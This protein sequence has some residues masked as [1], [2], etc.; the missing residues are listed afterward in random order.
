MNDPRGSYWRKW[1]LH[2]HTPASFHWNGGK[3]FIKMNAA[4]K[5]TALN[6]IIDTLNKSDVA[7]FA[8][9]DYWTFDGFEE[10][11]GH[12]GSGKANL[13]KTLFPGME[14]RVEAPVNYRLNVQVLLS[15]QLTRQQRADFK[16]A[17]RLGGSG[18]SISEEALIEFGRSLSSDKARKHGF[19]GNYAD[20]DARL[21]SLGSQTAEVTRESLVKAKKAIPEGNCL[22]VLPYDTSD[23]LAKLDW[24]EHP[25]AD[26]YFMQSADMFETRTQENVDLF[27]GRRTKANQAFFDHFLTTMGGKPKPAI[28]GSD[29]HKLSDYGSFPGDRATWIKADPT[30]E[31][32][33]KTL[34]EPLGRSYIGECPKQIQAIEQRPTK[35]IDYVSIKKK[36]ES[37]LSEHWFDCD[38]PINPGLVAIIGNK[39]TGKSALG[40]T[41]GLLGRTAKSEA[42]SFL[43][44]KR[45]RQPKNNKARHFEGKLIWCSGGEET[46]E[47][48]LNP[49]SN[50]YELIKYIPQNYLEALCNELGSVEETGFD[51]ELRSVI[52][53]HVSP[54]NRLGQASLED[55]IRYKTKEANDRIAILKS[56]L[57]GITESIIAL[58]KRASP[59]NKTKL[60]SA[61]ATKQNELKSHNENKPAAVPKPEAS[62]EQKKQAEA[63]GKQLSDKKTELERADEGIAQVRE[64]LSKV[65]LLLSSADRLVGRLENFQRQ[66]E[67]L[68]EEAIPLILDLGLVQKDV[69]SIKISTEPVSAKRSELI[70]EQAKL[71]AELKPEESNSKAAI[72]SNLAA[73]LKVI[74]S[75]LDAPSK[76]YEAYVER[77]AEWEEARNKLIGSTETPE[78]IEYYKAEVKK[79]SLIPKELAAERKKAESKTKEIFRE[80]ARLAETY[81]ELYAPVQEF[82]DSSSVARDQLQL[83]FDVQISDVGFEAAFF[84][85]VSQGVR[86]TY[87]GAEEGKKRLRKLLSDSDFASEDGV[88]K[89]VQKLVESL[90]VDKR[91][92]TTKT[93]VADLVR[94]GQT[95]QSLYDYVYGLDYLLPKYSLGIAGK[96]LAE[97]SPG[98]R[99]ALLLVF[100]LLVDQNDCPLVIDQPEENLDNQ[101]VFNLLVPCIKEAKQRRQI[102]VI[103]HNPNLAVV[104]DAEQV[105]ACSID[106]HDGNR[107]S[108]VSGAIE[109]PKINKLIVDILEGTRPAFDNRDAKYLKRTG[110]TT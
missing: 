88:V 57:R 102:I 32:L 76:A 30:F 21:L 53:S 18:R 36:S 34:I 16:A 31:G 14:L 72:R 98:E 100:Y 47:L 19:T 45:F 17:L 28:S 27:L 73:E 78:S 61:L 80:K 26:Q 52:F 48:H 70:D 77:K 92:N 74:Q 81:R 108:Y 20:D 22:T 90:L 65:N 38:I 41:V 69:L 82:I 56:E 42:F 83:R 96:P 101:T 75:K 64:D 3:R 86:G 85:Q 58:E 95:A 25:C 63:L 71:E 8:V 55:L 7:A 40:E 84:S 68:K 99:G 46:G 87:C 33:K 105:I 4:E 91:D 5:E 2:I 94:K 9:V 54:E 62:P 12:I 66:A 110:T 106:K 44:E 51:H 107:L 10:I 23:G 60:E 49:A 37:T 24:A 93:S 6:Q 13:N 29:A 1:D 59:E 97:L 109:N 104:C 11:L 79:L 39:G 15:D 43:S 89:F 103:T 67:T 50:A 35:F